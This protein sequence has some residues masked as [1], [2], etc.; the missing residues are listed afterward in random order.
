MALFPTGPAA[1]L[2]AA[3]AMLRHI[4]VY[5]QHRVLC[6]YEAI[7]IGIGVNAGTVMLGIIGHE[8]F[9]QGTAI[10]DAVNLAS[11]IEGLTRPTGSR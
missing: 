10:S 11:R 4:P 9:M 8:R 3:I 1:A 7:H 5:N 6:G 2:D